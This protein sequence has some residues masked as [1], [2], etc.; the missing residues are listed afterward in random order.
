MSAPE[1]CLYMCLT[2]ALV[3]RNAPSRWMAMIFFQSANGKS[4]IGCTIWMPAFDTR[5]STRPNAATVFATPALTWSSL[6]T[7]M[8]T[9]DRRLVVAQLARG[10]R[11]TV[12]VEVGDDDPATGLQVALGDGMADAAGGAG[13]EGHFSVEPHEHAPFSV[14]EIVVDDLAEP[15]RQVG[16]DV[17]SRDD[18]A[19]RQVGDR[20]E[21]MRPEVE[22]RRAGPGAF[23]DDVLQPV[24]DELARCADVPSTCGMIFSR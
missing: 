23:H 18:L 24:V 2:Q 20:R 14:L 16:D 19:H 13:D 11:R 10:L 6:V 15:E 3:V 1:P 17:R 21:R 4:S 8:A 12:D 7:S 9:A 22:R 5:M